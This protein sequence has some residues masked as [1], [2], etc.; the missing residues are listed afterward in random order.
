MVPNMHTARCLFANKIIKPIVHPLRDAQGRSEEFV[1]GDNLA[2]SLQSHLNNSTIYSVW[3]DL[4]PTISGIK[5]ITWIEVTGPSYG[6]GQVGEC[7]VGVLRR[8]GRVS[9]VRPETTWRELERWFAWTI[10]A[11]GPLSAS[12]PLRFG[13][14]ASFVR[15]PVL[16]DFSPSR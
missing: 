7:W 6:P 2:I 1:I 16:F 4:I 5:L 9:F 10:I 3:L 11:P 13:C 12:C 8:L 15:P 14:I